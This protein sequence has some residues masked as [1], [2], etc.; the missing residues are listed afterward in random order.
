MSSPFG[1]V[2]PA[3]I[4]FSGTTDASGNAT[5]KLRPRAAFWWSGKMV[6][7]LASGPAIWRAAIGPGAVGF[8]RGQRAEISGLV[9]APGDTIAIQVISGPSNTA[10]GGNLIGVQ[11]PSMQEV[12]VGFNAHP[13]TIALDIV[14]AGTKLATV[15]APAGG[16]SGPQS[17]PLPAGAVAI[18]FASQVGTTGNTVNVVGNVSG[19]TY[20][21]SDTNPRLQGV[22]LAQDDTAVT[23]TVTSG[24]VS[25]V[26][27]D[28]LT[29]P[30]PVSFFVRQLPG[31]SLTVQEG[32]SPA[33]WQAPRAT[34]SLTIAAAGTTALVPA[35][36]GQ[37]IYVFGWSLASDGTAAGGVRT[38]LQPHLGNAF[39]WLSA[40]PVGAAAGAAGG[41]PMGVALALDFVVD[42]LPAGDTA[43]AGVTYSQA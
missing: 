36:A 32:T 43:L 35:V 39:A 1:G 28:V 15:I 41:A 3:V 5:V 33:P 21:N 42:F 27:I 20:F 30:M 11:A 29:W 26:P 19:I 18:G 9:V 25:A 40:N 14:G 24:G 10:F 6:A 31:D 38:R 37:Q 17:L 2:L 7:E 34:A 4:P 12:A 16:S 22:L 8:G 23:V 13:N